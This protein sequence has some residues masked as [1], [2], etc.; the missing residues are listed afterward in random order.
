MRIRLPFACA[1]VFLLLTTAYLGLSSFH[2][3]PFINDK[4]LHAI[5]FFFL[6]TCFYWILDT[7]RR[8]NLNFT[9]LVCT[10]ILGIG[11]EV[12][13]GFLPNGRVFDLFDI[14]AN[15]AGS[16]A[17]VALS[18]WY[19][20]RM[21]ERKRAAK[22]YMVVPGEEEA[23]LELGEG[24]GAQESGIVGSAPASLEAE[25]DNWDEN[26]ED[27]WDDEGQAGTDS[28]EGEGPKTPSASSAGETEHQPEPK[29][30]V[31]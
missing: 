31:E 11:S 4:V 25:V 27:T 7:T 2:L 22:Q 17:A 1:F 24:V 29:K 30:R 28:L 20:K 14:A 5:T 8:R 21:L 9:L 16:L 13:Q 26:A 3:Q 18:S 23:D 6:T 10:G 12:L 19:H 15:I